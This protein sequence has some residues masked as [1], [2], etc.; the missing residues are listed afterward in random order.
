M[1]SVLALLF[2]V[3]LVLGIV[4]FVRQ[5]RF[6]V[7]AQRLARAIAAEGG[8]DR[9]GLARDPK[10]KVLPEVAVPRLE[11]ARAKADE[12]PDD[13]RAWFQLGVAYGD[14]RRPQDARQAVRRA[15]ALAKADP[16]GPL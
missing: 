4:L 13:W 16:E 12:T 15:V 2:L 6:G 7:Q 14:A 1:D 3:L 9:E 10:G 11:A 8:F 5:A